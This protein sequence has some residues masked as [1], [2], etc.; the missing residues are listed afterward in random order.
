MKISVVVTVLN[1]ASNIKRLVKAL[2]QQTLLPDEV[3]IVDGG[4]LDTTV[5]R[6]KNLKFK[7]KNS[8]LKFYSFRGNR[9]VCRNY[10]IKRARNSI[11]VV[12]DAGG[13]PKRDWLEKI[14]A[15]FKNFQV[16][17]VSGYYRSLGRTTFEKS[18]TPYFLVMSDRVRLGHEFLP[19]SRSVAFR[20]S[21]WEKAGGYPEKFSHN[22][23]LVFAD[24]IKNA[25]YKFYFEP[26]AIVYWHPPAALRQ[27]AKQF[28]RFALGDTE[29]GIKRPKV[30]YIFLR[31]AVGV[32]LILL[33]FYEVFFLFSIFYFLYS[34]FKN[35]RYVKEIG[36]LFWLPVIQVTSDFAVMMGHI[37]GM[38]KYAFGSRHNT[39]RRK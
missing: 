3:V 32:F 8:R 27:A 17:V 4:S 2:L 30:K 23:D 26:D 28:F 34:I 10:G 24:N 37:C 35:F 7:I 38:I 33:R 36:G 16:K 18:I 25:G 12:T 14:T 6:I 39:K 13:Y 5:S 11:I 15:P 31:Y 9:A 29:S 19:S 1:E 20:K 21:V 22:E